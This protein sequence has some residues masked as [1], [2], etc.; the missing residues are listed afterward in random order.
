MLQIVQAVTDADLATVRTLLLE[1]QADIG[2]DLCFQG[3][4]AELIGL[5]GSYAPPAGRLLIATHDSGPVGCVALQAVAAA[6]CE[7]KR[8]YV[9]P[10]ARG[11]GVGRALVAW[12]LDEAR[13]SGYS[14]IV[15]DTLPTMTAAQCLYEHLGF[16]EITA[17]RPNPVAGTRYLGKSLIETR[18]EGRSNF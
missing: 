7:M 11:L 1:Y 9:R 16:R 2:V 18:E 14:Q 15:L 17:Y 5:P 8:L 6:R 4:A 12:V 10:V 13:A 3:F